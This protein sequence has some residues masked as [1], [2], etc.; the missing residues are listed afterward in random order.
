MCKCSLSLR[1]SIREENCILD[2]W[3]FLECCFCLR[4]GQMPVVFNKIRIEIIHYCEVI[5]K[6]HMQGRSQDALS[7][8]GMEVEPDR[9]IFLKYRGHDL[10]LGITRINAMN[11]SLDTHLLKNVRSLKY[12]IWRIIKN[13]TVF[14]PDINESCLFLLKLEIFFLL[15][16]FDF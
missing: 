16:M 15:L 8:L 7:L 11:T 13:G 12:L 6:Q 2:V 4:V 1:P 5:L 10:Y 9:M 3:W 14:F